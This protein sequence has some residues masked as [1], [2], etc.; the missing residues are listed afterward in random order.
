MTDQWITPEE[1]DEVRKLT[2]PYFTKEAV[3]VICEQSAAH[4]RHLRERLSYEGNKRLDICKM[5]REH[6]GDRRDEFLETIHA[7]LLLK[8]PSDKDVEWAKNNIA[9][10]E[11]EL[12]DE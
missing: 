5:I 6:L 2:K 1:L 12:G 8:E 3:D 10:V 11:K 4:I 9:T 7:M